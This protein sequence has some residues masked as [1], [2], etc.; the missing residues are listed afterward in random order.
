MK[1]FPTKEL[2]FKLNGKQSE[3]LNRLERR[4][5]KSEELKSK[6]TDKSFIGKINGND[7]KIISSAYGKGALSVMS[8]KIDSEKGHVDVKIHKI[9]KIIFSFFIIIPLIGFIVMIL[10][11]TEEFSPIMILVLIG[12]ILI[13]RYIF[14]GYAF[15]R[16][17]KESLNRL[18]DVLDIEWIKKA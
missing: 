6:F 11:K 3:T 12:Q 13:V 9:F 5:E 7:F 18:R 10:S 15:K 4:T 14:I 17:S 1:I 8:G 2:A 16:F